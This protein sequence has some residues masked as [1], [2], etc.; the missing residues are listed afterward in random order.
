M[1]SLPLQEGGRS[2]L[3][4]AAC[5]FTLLV[6]DGTCYTFGIFMEP[7]RYACGLRLLLISGG[8]KAVK[9]SDFEV[10]I[11]FVMLRVIL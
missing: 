4:V 11:F 6:L 1:S 7:L 9:L 8:H 10:I 3:V 2:W 5:F